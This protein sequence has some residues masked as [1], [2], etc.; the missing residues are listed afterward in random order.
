MQGSF[1]LKYRLKAF[2][3]GFKG[4][5]FKKAMRPISIL[6]L[7]T[8]FVIG[9]YWFFHRVIVYLDGLPSRVGDE[10]IV[11]LINLVFITLFMMVLFSCLI[12]SLSVYYLS[13][14]LELLHSLPISISSIVTAR[15]FQCMANSSWMVLLFSLPMFTAYGSYFKVSWD[16]YLYLIFSMVPFL[17]IPCLVAILA[18]MVLMKL[19][20][21]HKTHQI[22]TFMGLFFLVGVVV[23]LRFLSQDKFFG[24][25]VSDEQI[26]AFVASLK[27]PDYP[28]L[29]SNRITRWLTGWIEVKRELP[30][31]QTLILWGVAGGLFIL[32]LW[33]GSR[34]YFQGWCLVQE[35]RST[36]LA[37]RGTKRKTFFQNLPLSAPGKA[38]LNKDLKIFIRD[39]EQWSQLFILFAL[40]CVYIFNIMHL[41]LDNIVL[42]EVVSVLNVGLVG[43]VMAAL[44]SRFVF[45]SPSVEGKSFWLI[46]TRPVTMQKFLAGKFWMFFPPLLFIA[47][48]LVVVSNQ[49]LEV[50]AY[51]MSVSVVGVFL[52]TFGLTSLGLGLGTLYPK[53]D[54]E[55]IA[56]ISSSTGGVLFM[57]L[58][59]SYIGVVLML[60]ARPLYVHFNEKFL[61]KSIG[62]LE[63]PVCYILIFIL[64]WAI[65]HIPL[66]LGARSLNARDI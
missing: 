34:I 19:Y 10:L 35:V 23:Y 28:F 54:Y 5:G 14:D 16:Y 12:V 52:L 39:P 26:M 21:T 29:P 42:R 38:L 33:V 15:Y 60:G 64:T 62:G 25:D 40:M 7:G 20:P 49:L 59:L 47:E 55:N 9:D 22:M 57:I 24:Q 45:S 58:A 37:A 13:R 32:H 17:A 30:F 36:P 18:I 50:D 51:V 27:A 44:I 53:F 2:A 65:A 8:L 1:L 31:M 4:L 63:V 11:Q 61:F 48:L 46:Y 6:T 41:P 3:N 66:R 56:E 43:F